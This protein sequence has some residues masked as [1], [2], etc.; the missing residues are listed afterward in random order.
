M[1]EHE[2]PIAGDWDPIAQWWSDEIADDPIYASD[3]H[4]LYRVLTEGVGGLVADLAA[5]SG[6]FACRLGDFPQ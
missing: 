5:D 2:A 6:Y 3:V 1:E 4:P